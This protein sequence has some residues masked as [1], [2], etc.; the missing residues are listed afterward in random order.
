M[1][2]PPRPD[3]RSCALWRR[4]YFPREVTEPEEGANFVAPL[5]PLMKKN[6]VIEAVRDWSRSGK[7]WRKRSQVPSGPAPTAPDTPTA[8]LRN[9]EQCNERIKTLRHTSF[10]HQQRKTE[11][12]YEFE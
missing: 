6:E 2:R 7:I 10:P 1:G 11:K 8:T 3:R 5:H 9:Q 4:L 12:L